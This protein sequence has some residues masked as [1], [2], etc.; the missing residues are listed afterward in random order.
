M[1]SYN[2]GFEID[3]DFD[4]QK[5]IQEEL[6]EICFFCPK[7]RSLE[8]LPSK[9]REST[10]DFGLTWVNTNDKDDEN[11]QDFILLQRSNT[12]SFLELRFSSSV[13]K[14]STDHYSFSASTK[15]VFDPASNIQGSWELSVLADFNQDG[16][17]DILMRHQASG[18]NLIRLLGRSGES[19]I[20]DVQLPD[21]LDLNWDFVDT[22]DFNQDGH[23]DILLRHH[24]TGVN[25]V[26]NMNNTSLLSATTLAPISD[27]DWEVAAT[28][29]FTQDGKPDLLLRHREAGINLV[30]QM[31]GYDIIGDIPL[32][33]VSD[34]RWHIE[35]VRDFNKDGNPDIIWRHS[36]SDEIAVWHMNG[37]NI[38]LQDRIYLSIAP[39]WTVKI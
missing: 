26:W 2:S 4:I 7:L 23:T 11:D 3:F 1:K 33:E 16:N 12:N 22:A 32:L 18:Q 17:L 20:G 38:A 24:A 9:H 10:Y 36:K 13:Y 27:P 25:L 14:N 28:A 5:D 6:A 31:N 34:N 21:V 19:S 30:R 15:D 35:G 39:S 29:D 8:E 37:T